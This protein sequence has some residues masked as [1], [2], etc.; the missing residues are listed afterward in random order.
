LAGH[1]YRERQGLL[2]CDAQTTT[3]WGE[4]APLPHFSQETLDDVIREWRR[5]PP[6]SLPSLRFAMDS[7]NHGLDVPPVPVNRL[8]SGS[9]SDVARRAT[10][11]A[12]SDRTVI[13]LKVGPTLGTV[14]ECAR[15][16][17]SIRG[18]LAPGV[19]LRLDA[20]R[21]WSIHEAIEFGRSVRKFDVDYIEEPTCDPY[22]LERFW[23]ETCVPYALDETLRETVDLKSFPHAAAFIVKPMLHGGHA[24]LEPLQRWNKLLVFSGAFETGIGTCHVARLANEFSPGTA[25]GIDGYSWLTDDVLQPRLNMLSDRLSVAAPPKIRWHLL[26]ELPT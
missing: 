6:F 18:V 16:V 20:N 8:L 26:E 1:E 3:R 13:K 17:R 11:C 14:A 10:Q 25:V 22:D 24:D 2:F 19:R 23:L 12:E 4:A 7:L 5:G 15:T 21:A 9:P